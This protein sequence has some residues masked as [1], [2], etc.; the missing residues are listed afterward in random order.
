MSHPYPI[1]AITPRPGLLR[2]VGGFNLVIG[3]V[4]LLFGGAALYECGPFLKENHPFRLDPEFTQRVVIEM[5]RD[6]LNSLQTS[7]R[8]ARDEAEKKRL[9]AAI[10]DVQA[11]TKDDSGQFDSARVNAS[12][13]WVSRY[14]IGNLA[15][16][17]PLN[18]LLMLAGLGL[19]ARR[20][21]ARRLALGVAALK[22]GRLLVLAALLVFTVVPALR[23]T[24]A[25]FASTNF[26]RAFAAHALDTVDR[27]AIRNVQIKPDE[28][29]SIIAAIGYGYAALA[30]GF[31]A[32][33]PAIVLIVLTRPGARAACGV[34]E[35]ISS[36]ATITPVDSARRDV[37]LPIDHPEPR[38]ATISWESA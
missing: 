3:F 27:S 30:L 13:P 29:V 8:A 23:D 37:W 15:S 16:G 21:W 2:A 36:R 28:L 25:A 34:S 14:M 18:L 26:G 24:T 4:L 17:P 31:G 6:L 38:P 19:L 33:W 5:N 1:E 35:N 9:A 11:I 12:L 10:A 7:A 22:I 20:N 32:I